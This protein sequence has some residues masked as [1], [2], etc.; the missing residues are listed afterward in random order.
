MTGYVFPCKTNGRC[1]QL[2]L[3][4]AFPNTW[5]ER[6]VTYGT[7]RI[8][9]VKFK[10]CTQCHLPVSKREAEWLNKELGYSL[11]D[12]VID[13]TFLDLLNGIE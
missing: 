5:I 1:R 7:K 3:E 8:F 11:S 4:K 12:I 13:P 10:C 6:S 9:G 2:L